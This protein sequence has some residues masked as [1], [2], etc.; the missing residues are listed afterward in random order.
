MTCNLRDE[1]FHHQWYE[2]N[3]EEWENELFA[4]I[5]KIFDDIKARQREAERLKR[6]SPQDYQNCLL[7]VK[8]LLKVRK[9]EHIRVR[10]MNF[11]RVQK[12][13]QMVEQNDILIVKKH[14]LD[15]DTI[16]IQNLI[17]TTKIES[18]LAQLDLRKVPKWKRYRAIKELQELYEGEGGISPMIA[19]QD[20]VS[21]P[22]PIEKILEQQKAEE[23]H[24][25]TSS[26]PRAEY[27]S[28]DILTYYSQEGSVVSKQ[29]Q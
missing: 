7:K 13:M 1:D 17:A 11:L 10:M 27:D 6:F 12:I 14:V 5:F 20:D 16:R 2:Y 19:D 3:E 23:E 25:E 21:T 15:E 26:Q 18:E 4:K 22:P 28:E 29:E 24:S 9:M 8:Y